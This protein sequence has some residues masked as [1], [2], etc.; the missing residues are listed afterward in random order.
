MAS[1]SVASVPPPAVWSVSASFRFQCA[2]SNSSAGWLAV[3]VTLALEGVVTVTPT[4]HTSAPL[5][6]WGD[7]PAGL[8]TL[9][10]VALTKSVITNEPLFA[11]VAQPESLMVSPTMARV[12]PVSP[13]RVT[14]GVEKAEMVAAVPAG[15]TAWI[16]AWMAEHSAPI[17]EL[18]G[19]GRT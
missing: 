11:L 2:T 18:A 15:H 17:D 14:F 10:L 13:V 12:M 9:T 1:R 7:A 19:T 3:I 5:F 8:F 4:D 6:A 16:S